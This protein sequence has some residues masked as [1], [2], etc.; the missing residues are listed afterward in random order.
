MSEPGSS[1]PPGLVQ[2]DNVIDTSSCW[3]NNGTYIGCNSAFFSTYSLNNTK[4]CGQVRGYQYG[5]PWALYC[6]INNDNCF[7]LQIKTFGVTLTYSNN[8]CKH[9]WTYAVGISEQ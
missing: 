4:V 1:C 3:I 9:I 8:P 7:N 2:Y 5:Y 6:Y